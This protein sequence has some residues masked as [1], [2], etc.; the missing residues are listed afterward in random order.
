[1]EHSPLSVTT[2]ELIVGVLAATI[3]L[4]VFM[5]VAVASYRRSRCLSRY[6]VWRSAIIAVFAGLFPALWLIG[7]LINRDRLQREWQSYNAD[8]EA[9]TL[10]PSR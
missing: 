4:T 1:M 8:H 6:P 7:S 10:T 3:A 9:R 2:G 5:T